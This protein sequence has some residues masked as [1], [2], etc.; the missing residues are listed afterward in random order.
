MVWQFLPAIK[1]YLLLLYFSILLLTIRQ[2]CSSTF[3]WKDV[4]PL[5]HKGQTTSHLAFVTLL[6]IL[7]VDI[8][9]L[10]LYLRTRLFALR[11]VKKL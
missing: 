10:S 3:D 11:R 9:R 5:E 7:A 8:Y 1:V 4:H 6:M 2:L